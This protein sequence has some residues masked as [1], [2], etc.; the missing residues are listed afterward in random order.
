MKNTTN[1]YHDRTVLYAPFTPF[2]VLFCY[3]IETF[4]TDDLQRLVDFTK[5]LEPVKRISQ[6][7]QK[8]HRLCEVLRDVAKLYIDAKMQSQQ[9]DEDMSMIGENFDIYLSRLGLFPQQQIPASEY[10]A[11]S[12]SEEIASSAM[13]QT[14]QLG[15]WFSGNSHIMGLLEDDF[16]LEFN[17]EEEPLETL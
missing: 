16:L 5:S 7:I 17:S 4:N 3:V 9:K 12:G 8:F 13:T 14:S 1:R 11:A 2:I 10:Y 6:S 15:D